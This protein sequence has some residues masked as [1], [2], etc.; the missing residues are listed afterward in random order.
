MQP[1]APRAT[2]SQQISPEWHVT[3]VDPHGVLRNKPAL[4][5]EMSHEISFV[6]WVSE[7]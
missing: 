3:S 2:R 1:A 6:G 5:R 4:G 7:A